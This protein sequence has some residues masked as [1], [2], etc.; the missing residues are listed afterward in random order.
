VALTINDAINYVNENLVGTS[1][2]YGD[3]ERMLNGFNEEEETNFTLAEA[4]QAGIYEE[5]DECQQCGWYCETSEFN[6]EGFCEDCA[7]EEEE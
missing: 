4:E 1:G 2:H 7:S 5:V 6:S 3:H